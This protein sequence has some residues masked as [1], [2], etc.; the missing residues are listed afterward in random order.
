MKIS[1]E[2]K[3][4]A[5]AIVG[6]A[7]L[8]IGFNFLKGKN[9]FKKDTH[10]YAV[11]Q[12]VQGLTKSNPV[13]ING[14]QI[15]RIESLDGGKDMR[16]IL[17]T[18]N[19][20]KDVNIPSN[21]LAVINPNLL[22]SPSLEIQLGSATTYLQN[23]DTL[24]TTLSGGAFDEALKIIN[25]VLYEVRNAV[26]SLDS[27]LHIVTGVFDPTT[28][29]NIRGIVENLNTT[30]ASFAITAASLQ[31]MMDAQN[32]ALAKSLGNVN[33]FTANLNA[34]SG[35]LDSIL[36]NA[37]IVSKNFAAVDLQKT[38]DS[39]N[40]A[41]NNFKQG[42]EKIN[43]KEGSLG[44]LLNDKSLYD[45]LQSTSNK[46]NILIDDIRVHPKRYVGISIFGKKD[47]GNFITAPLIDD[48]LKV[49]KQ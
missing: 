37:R 38:L 41:V 30:T 24:L 35:K 40:V 43:S 3:I 34:N 8:V 27:V 6:I 11:Y 46:L 16:R 9:L 5:L 33:S 29:N 7:L 1:N 15:G 4:G 23:G 22:G 13:V 32:G 25:P 31:Q 36:E 39:L 26:K 14:L 48:T 44:L 42:S 18:V 21:S 12:D 47:K 10:I 20:F 28:K 19:L 17:V 49:V 2:T 45:N